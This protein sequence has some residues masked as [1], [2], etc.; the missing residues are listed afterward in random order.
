VPD[1]SAPL[2]LLH[3][4]GVELAAKPLESLG[5]S[6]REAEVLA[7]V[8]EGKTNPEIALILSLSPRT[9]QTYVDRIFRKLGVETRTAAAATAFAVMTEPA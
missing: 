1:R 7:W 2:L 3:E 6:G 8:A 5:L 4:E 9:V